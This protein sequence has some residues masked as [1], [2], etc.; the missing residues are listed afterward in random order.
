MHVVFHTVEQSLDF[1]RNNDEEV[2]VGAEI[3]VGLSALTGSSQ[4]MQRNARHLEENN[5]KFLVPG[6]LGTRLPFHCK[7]LFAPYKDEILKDFAFIKKSAPSVKWY[8]STL[9]R[10]VE[11]VDDWSA[12]W[13]DSIAN[14]AL[15]RPC[16]RAA[17]DDG[18]SVL[19]E[20]NPGTLYSRTALDLGAKIAIAPVSTTT[21]DEED[22]LLRCTRLAASLWVRIGPDV[23]VP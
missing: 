19:I 8:S 7:N 10:A 18:F 9:G 3:G 1:L 23:F 11:G 12:F 17:L 5:V 16:I 6:G 2:C 14:P 21:D 4:A 20:I 22:I 13:Y 15:S